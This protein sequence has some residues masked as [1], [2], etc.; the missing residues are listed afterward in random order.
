[1]CSSL[2]LY[3][4]LLH[5]T[6]SLA[7]ELLKTG[8]EKQLMLPFLSNLSGQKHSEFSEVKTSQHPGRQIY[9]LNL[10]IWDMFPY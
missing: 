2:L 10:L 1:M 4:E 3:Q 5:A 7:E 6:D 8:A 9:Y